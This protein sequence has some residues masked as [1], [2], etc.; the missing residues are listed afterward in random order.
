LLVANFEFDVGL[1]DVV[2]VVVVGAAVDVSTCPAGD[3]VVNFV[4]GG[5]EVEVGNDPHCQL[6]ADAH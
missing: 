4:A 5:V 1:A 6:K 2:L 3:A